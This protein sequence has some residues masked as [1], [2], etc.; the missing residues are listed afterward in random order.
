MA[1]VIARSVTR[2]RLR[3]TAQILW[4]RKD[5]SIT[6]LT[7]PAESPG[8]QLQPVPMPRRDGA[9]KTISGRDQPSGGPRFPQGSSPLR[10]G[11]GKV[12]YLLIFMTRPAVPISQSALVKPGL[13]LATL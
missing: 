9:F 11:R 10:C 13:F 12:L 3:D 8:G 7:L 1:V 4:L 2:E 6:E 5:H